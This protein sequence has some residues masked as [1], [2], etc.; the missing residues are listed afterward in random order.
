MLYTEWNMDDFGAVRY[1]EGHEKG[2]LEGHEKGIL[3][4]HEKGREESQEETARKAL[5]KGLPLEV[6]SD[7]TG[8]DAERIMSLQAE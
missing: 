5:A 6:I 2:V 1:E 4:G 8:L 7:I 3:E